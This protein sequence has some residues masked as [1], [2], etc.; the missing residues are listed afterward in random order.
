MEFL[1]MSQAYD[2]YGGSSFYSPVADLLL[3]RLTGNYGGAVD[4]VYFTGFLRSEHQRPR[5]TLERLF[6]QFQGFLDKL[7]KVTFRRKLKRIEIQFA[8]QAFTADDDKSYRLSVEKCHR[9]GTEVAAALTL[10]TKRI[11]PTDD[12]DVK[13]FLNDANVLLATD[14]GTVEEWEIVRKEAK[15]KRQALRATKTPWELLEIDWSQYHP[16]ARKILDDP[17]F[18]EC[19]NEL[20]PNGNDTGADLLAD[21]RRWHKRNRAVSPLTFLNGLLNVWGIEE[22]DWTVTDEERVREMRKKDSIALNLCNEAAIA[23]A[24]A[25]VKMRGSC[26][27]DIVRLA[28]AALVRTGI[29]LKDS[30]LSNET[31]T[32]WE[33]AIPKMQRKLESL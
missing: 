24:F 32:A 18:W 4:S 8:S 25:V 6:Q 19:A 5:P 30:N 13:R 22:V 14:I 17:F 23:L 15:E 21:Y 33:E 28:L 12:F 26:P 9:A 11:K 29:L 2:K 7:P 16:Q 27:S 3:L 20:A 31:K 1:G 10:I